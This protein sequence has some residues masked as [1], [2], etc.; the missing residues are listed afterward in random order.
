M[1]HCFLL[2][3]SINTKRLKIMAIFIILFLGVQ[4]LPISYFTTNIYHS[5]TRFSSSEFST[6]HHFGQKRFAVETIWRIIR[7]HLTAVF[8]GFRIQTCK[9]NTTIF[10]H[11]YMITYKVCLVEKMTFLKLTYVMPHFSYSTEKVETASRW[12]NALLLNFPIETF[13]IVC[14]VCD[15]DAIVIRPFLCDFVLT[16]SASKNSPWSSTSKKTG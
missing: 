5:Q 3:L 10:L 16:E 8:S 15:S 7:S 9:Q 4:Y 6:P 13:E 1:S 11:T 2:K 14:T 12:D